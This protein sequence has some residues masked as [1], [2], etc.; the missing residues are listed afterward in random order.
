ML[1]EKTGQNICFDDHKSLFYSISYNME[2]EQA[3]EDNFKLVCQADGN[4][5]FL[6]FRVLI[7]A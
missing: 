2:I 1:N 7:S 4:T 3:S 6:R 5:K